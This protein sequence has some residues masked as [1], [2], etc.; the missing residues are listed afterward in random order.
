MNGFKPQYSSI[1]GISD[2]RR[3]PRLNKIRL[4]IKKKSQKTGNEYPA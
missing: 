1:K 2:K 3:L 4:G